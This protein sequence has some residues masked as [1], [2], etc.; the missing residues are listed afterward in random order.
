MSVEYRVRPDILRNIQS[1]YGAAA[2]RADKSE[3]FLSPVF[4]DAGTITPY[5]LSCA[6]GM[7]DGNGLGCEAVIGTRRSGE[8]G[9]ISISFTKNF[10]AKAY[11]DTLAKVEALLKTDANPVDQNDH[12]HFGSPFAA[13]AGDATHLYCVSEGIAPEKNWACYLYVAERMP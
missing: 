5:F 11:A 8:A 13:A 7:P 9:A 10:S 12:K 1:V 4:N 3:A 2:A 6:A